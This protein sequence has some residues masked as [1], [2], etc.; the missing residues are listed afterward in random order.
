MTK[1]ALPYAAGVI[2]EFNPFHNGHAY[3]LRTVRKKIG[4]SGCIICVMS[5]CFVQR[6]EP[7]AADPY[8]RAQ[9]AIHGGADLVVELPFP[10]SAS[11]AEFFSD[12]GISILSKLKAKMISF[13]SETCDLSLLQSAANVLQSPAFRLQSADLIRNGKGAADAVT[14]LLR[15]SID[16]ASGKNCPDEFPSSNDI[17][18]IHY[19][20]AMHASSS[21][22][23]PFPVLRIGQAYRD[24]T[25]LDPS[26]PSANAL[27]Q[28][29][30]DAADEPDRLSSLLA[31]A[32]PPHILQLWLD[33]IRAGNAPA[34]DTSL[35]SFMHTFFR[36]ADPDYLT[37][38]PGLSG[39]LSHRLVQSALETPTYDAFLRS[40]QSRLYTN[41]RLRRAMLYAVLGVK[42]SDLHSPPAY[43][44]LLAAN[45]RGCFYLKCLRA[46]YKECGRTVPIVTKPADA[47]ACRQTELSL[48]ANALFTL[49]LPKPATAESRLKKK[50]YIQI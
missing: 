31:D 44:A 37:D 26:A 36:L 13:G 9:T 30:Q 3:L 46:I 45:R 7:A 32:M 4:E 27:R 29:M 49:C 19:L 42:D 47:P 11:C 25:L 50:P 22:M 6:G 15:Q 23:L 8:L 24:K 39:G 18:A 43:T 5:G 28:I 1:I 33:E 17:L 34:G 48:R 21:K 10:W 41:A 38:F 35:L 40:I 20:R 2:C 14:T 16:A 12:A